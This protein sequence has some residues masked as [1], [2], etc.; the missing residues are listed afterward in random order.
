MTVDANLPV[1]P[2]GVSYMVRVE[3]S[4]EELHGGAAAP[5]EGI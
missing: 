2:E 5:V 4:R 3:D 1:V